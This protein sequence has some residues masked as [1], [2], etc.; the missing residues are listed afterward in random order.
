MCGIYPIPRS[1]LLNALNK[2]DRDEWISAV[3]KAIPGSKGTKNDVK[4]P[5]QKLASYRPAPVVRQDTAAA[6]ALLGSGEGGEDE[7]VRGG[8]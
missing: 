4:V 1:Y 5:E 7:T 3:K 8:G 6:A 2:G